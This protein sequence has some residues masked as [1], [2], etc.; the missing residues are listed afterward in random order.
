MTWTWKPIQSEVACLVCKS[1]EIEMRGVRMTD[2]PTTVRVTYHCNAGHGYTVS[3]AQT[4]TGITRTTQFGLNK[5][6]TTSDS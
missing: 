1:L 6:D 2:E 4:Q 3:L 5:G